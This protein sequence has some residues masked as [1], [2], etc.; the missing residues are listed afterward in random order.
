MDVDV[1]KYIKNNPVNCAAAIISISGAWLVAALDQSLQ[2]LGFSLWVASNIL[3]ILHGM[4][5][6]DYFLVITF[7]AYFIMNVIGI[8][9]RIGCK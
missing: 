4:N 2:Q 6:K 1:V 7:V 8:S 3:W 5:K 9:N